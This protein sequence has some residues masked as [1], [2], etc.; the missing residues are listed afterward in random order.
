[1]NRKKVFH[2][3]NWKYS[4]TLG[5]FLLMFGIT[6]AFGQK[7]TVRG[8]VVDDKGDPLIGAGVTIKN[9][10]TGTMTDSNG[11]FRLDVEMGN[12]L[13]IKYLG[14]QN[15]ELKVTKHDLGR[16]VLVE[17]LNTMDELV[18][19]G[20]GTQRKRDIAGS[21]TSISEKVL[22]Q[23]A[24]T[25]VMAGLQGE[26]AGLQITSVSGEPG[27]D[28][29]I[30]IRGLSTFKSGTKPLYVVD[31][32]IVTS[33]TFYALNPTDITN[34]QVLKDAASMSI[35]GSR[36]A[37]GVILVTT[38]SGDI[39]KP[40]VSVRYLNSYGTLANK[41]P[42]LN[43]E[44]RE[45]FESTVQSAASRN[46]FQWFRSSNDS[47]SLSAQTSNDYQKVISQT[48]VRH[49]ATI[50]MQTGT[51]KLN[52]YTSLGVLDDKGIILT[53]YAKRYT[54]RLKA[55]Y[56]VSPFIKFTS[57]ISGSYQ[58]GNNISEGQTFYNAIR[59]PTQSI[60]YFPDG[61]LVAAY[62]SNPSGKRN[63]LIELFYR[64][65]IYNRYQALFNQ[66]VEI[67]FLKYF[68]LNSQASANIQYS[69]RLQYTGPFTQTSRTNAESG[70]D[71]G[72]RSYGFNTDI[73]LESYLIF[74]KSFDNKHNV[75]AM[76]GISANK[77]S[78]FTP[79][80]ISMNNFL[81]KNENMY[82]PQA[83]TLPSTA[84]VDGSYKNSASQFGR[85][86]YDYLGRYIFRA[87]VRRDGSSV[88]GEVNRWGIF[89]STSAAWRL[90][91]EFFMDWAKPALDDAKIRIS[92]GKAGND[93]IGYYD[94]RTMFQV[95]VTPYTYGAVPG[96]FPRNML[97]NPLLKWE[98]TTQTN[99]GTDLSFF[100]GRLNITG[101]Y[102][103]KSTSDLLMDEKLPSE[104]G[105]SERVVNI[106][107]VQNKGV[108][109]SIN[110][111]PVQTRNW[112]WETTV[113]WT[114][115]RQKVLEI[116]GDAY[117]ESNDWWVEAG[118]PT[119]NFYGYKNLGIYRYDASN[120]YTQDYQ[121]RL[122]PVF[123]RDQYGNVIITKS[124]GPELTGYQYPDGTD[125][126]WKPD[127]TGNQVYAL[128]KGSEKF[129]G[130][131]VIWDD[132]NHDGIIDAGDKQILGNAQSDWY[133]GWNNMVRYKNFSLNFNVYMNWGG[134]IYNAL[135]YD[136][137]RYGDNTSNA[138][139]RGVI[140]GWR[141]QGQITNWYAPGN[142]IR[143]TENGRSLNSQYLEDA[144]FIRIQNVRLTY[145]LPVKTI[146]FVQIQ[147]LQM[148]G[149]V[150]NLATWTNYRG[151]D[152]EFYTGSVLTPGKDTQKYPK[153]R[154]FG[155][156][157]NLSF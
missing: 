112:R 102:Y 32:V 4:I 76:A 16:I 98:T 153:K 103:V 20:Y 99:V 26:V 114:R 81:I 7:I 14:F 78:F 128:M 127:G 19:V 49:D 92:W 27:A 21:I 83:T 126:G 94:A 31:G 129:K 74:S 150:N 79:A 30:V 46:Q 65:N 23:R 142:N 1:M 143:S 9:T 37:N 77:E 90:S 148:F 43:R 93:Q 84:S 152:P 133:A 3:F 2:L 45:I 138:D 110:A 119:G 62:E 141:Y 66:G 140:Q 107:A 97:G 51:D 149:Y 5:I 121:T 139:P 111:T 86:A 53:S 55:I 113:N 91:D 116:A 58:N 38:K 64:K 82:V 48:A 108:E 36:A 35:Y 40:R 68:T 72:R 54:A 155:F 6:N 60:I 47:L 69:D 145:Q 123:A 88:F 105:Y 87:S 28:S 24:P 34:I 52:I 25:N 18:V 50:T 71:N 42:Q 131:D 117:A 39:G 146:K 17:D 80:N 61:S 44:E 11:E 63:P 157:V 104:L 135:L 33:E 134:M 10:T 29:E 118:K 85:V 151:Y 67:K 137:T 130:G 95:S 147:S 8:G 109:I 75:E 125:Y 56:A 41:L 22:E 70:V 120:A 101:D 124:G 12:V 59:R 57:N 122:I 89:P 154:E 73:L 106:G 96:V 136:L 15:L 115:N 132:Y 144:S 13:A 100:R 156:G